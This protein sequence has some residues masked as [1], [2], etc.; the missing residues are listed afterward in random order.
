MIGPLPS[1]DAAVLISLLPGGWPQRVAIA[2]VR[3]H[4]SL[5]LKLGPWRRASG[6]RK[7]LRLVCAHLCE[8]RQKLEAAGFSS[9]DEALAEIARLRGRGDKA[10]GEVISVKFNP[11]KKTNE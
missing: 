8:E 10:E 2:M 7:A 11:N 4:R 1:P 3:K 6:T 9:L 5:L